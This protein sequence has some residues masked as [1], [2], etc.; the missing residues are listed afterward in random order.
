MP[1]FLT[2]IKE[3]KNIQQVNSKSRGKIRLGYFARWGIQ[4][5]KYLGFT[6]GILLN[7]VM[8]AILPSV[9]ATRLAQH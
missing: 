3:L 7:Q 4:R 8:A 1:T 9:D 2:K 5:G 6:R